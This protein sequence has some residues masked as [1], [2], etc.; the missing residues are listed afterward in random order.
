[1]ILTLFVVSSPDLM[2]NNLYRWPVNT[3]MARSPGVSQGLAEQ[4]YSSPMDTTCDDNTDV[5][6]TKRR[7]R[8]RSYFGALSVVSPHEHMSSNQ[9]PWPVNAG[10]AR[11]PGVSQGLAEQLYS[12][13]MDTTCDHN[14]DVRVTKRRSRPRSY[15][16][17]ILMS[18]GSIGLN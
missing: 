3:G 14:T 9:H 12:S 18:G 8:P 10:M 4:L 2:N 17:M 13:P 16:G 7:S 11:S 15:F 5:R 6:V 1:M